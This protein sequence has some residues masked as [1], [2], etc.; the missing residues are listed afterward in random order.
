[1]L[2]YSMQS[3]CTGRSFSNEDFHLGDLQLSLSPRLGDILTR[4]DIRTFA[5]RST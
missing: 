1:M 5:R 4:E 3:V 2:D